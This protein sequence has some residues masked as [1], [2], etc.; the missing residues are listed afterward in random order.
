MGR[1]EIINAKLHKTKHYILHGFSDLSEIEGSEEE[2][3]TTFRHTTDEIKQ[4]I[5]ER[6]ADLKID[7]EQ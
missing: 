4:R 1:P 5:I 2:K 6:F 3:M 7:N